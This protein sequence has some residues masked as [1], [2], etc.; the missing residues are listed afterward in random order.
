MSVIWQTLIAPIV[1]AFLFFTIF[2]LAF[3]G[4]SRVVGDVSYQGFLASGLIIMTMMQNSFANSSS[5]LLHSKMLG[6]I[7]DVLMPPLSSWEKCL[8]YLA[9][10]VTRGL[11]T[12]SALLIFFYDVLSWNTNYAWLFFYGIHACLFM[13]SIGLIAAIWAEKFDHMATLTNF[14][15][16]PLTFLS[17]TFYSVSRL[18]PSWHEFLAL[19]PIYYMIDGFRFALISH[20]EGG[21]A[22]GVLVI[23]IS[24]WLSVFIAWFL[25]KS[26]YRL[27]P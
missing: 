12:G 16:T 8:A 15:I 24:T 20:S 14:F 7:G 21:L 22:I 11:L 10:G 6:N 13:T 17:G 18:P 19:N 25:F 27:C 5:S 2:T 4:A 26:G 3:D 1:T 9:G 23:T